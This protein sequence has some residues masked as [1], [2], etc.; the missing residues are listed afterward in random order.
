MKTIQRT[1]YIADDGTEF[2][3]ELQCLAHE[4]VSKAV[5]V[6][7]RGIPQAPSEHGSFIRSSPSI[8]RNARSSLWTLVLTKYGESW[9]QYGPIEKAWRRMAS[10]DFVKGRIYDHPYFV[11]HPDAAHEAEGYAVH[12]AID[13]RLKE[14]SAQLTGMM[15]WHE[16]WKIRLAVCLCRFLGWIK[17]RFCI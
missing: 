13:A 11:E 12:E 9:P 4:A 8:L 1:I 10:W 16:R 3:N 5:E 2:T 7:F 6:I 17:N 14:I 15:P